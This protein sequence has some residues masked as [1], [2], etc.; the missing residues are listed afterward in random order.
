VIT[1]LKRTQPSARVGGRCGGLGSSCCY[2]ERGRGEIPAEGPLG[3]GPVELRCRRRLGQ[4]VPVYV[5]GRHDDGQVCRD[6]RYCG[7]D[8]CV[9]HPQVRYAPDR[10]RAVNHGPFVVIT[11][12][13]DRGGGVLEGS[14]LLTEGAPEVRV[15]LD[16]LA[17]PY[18]LR[19]NG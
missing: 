16:L 1:A 11:A 17:G 13:R 18:L 2:P 8:R 15:V 6:G 14:D 10:A 7:K 3:H 4:R 9:D 19:R 12:H 5:L